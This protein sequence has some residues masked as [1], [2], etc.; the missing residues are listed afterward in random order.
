MQVI[1]LLV[2]SCHHW[3]LKV[4]KQFNE[5]LTARHAPRVSRPT[6]NP[7]RPQWLSMKAGTKRA[8]LRESFVHCADLLT[9]NCCFKYD[10]GY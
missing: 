5:L 1:K 2:R 9:T 3:Q 4:C 8:I 6:S 10:L 7:G